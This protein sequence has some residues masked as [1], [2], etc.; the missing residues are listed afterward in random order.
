MFVDNCWAYFVC[1]N[2]KGDTPYESSLAINSFFNNIKTF[3]KKIYCS[4]F[5]NGNPFKNPQTVLI[6]RFEIEFLDI[7][8]W[9]IFTAIL[10]LNFAPHYL[11]SSA[12][13]KDP[14][15][16]TSS[17]KHLEYQLR[18]YSRWAWFLYDIKKWSSIVLLCSLT[19]NFWLVF[20]FVTLFLRIDDM[21]QLHCNQLQIEIIF[22]WK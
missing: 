8:R 10:K 15:V 19:S 6:I 20:L 14:S 1:E 9:N 7:P 4:R 12:P 3:E 11:R 16:L 22:G 18:E 2:T 5:E 17:T 21:Q 13:S